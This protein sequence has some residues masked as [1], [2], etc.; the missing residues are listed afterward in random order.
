MNGSSAYSAQPGNITAVENQ[1][2]FQVRVIW[3]RS[4]W[5]LRQLLSGYPANAGTSRAQKWRIPTR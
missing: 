3:V 2:I 1:S 4:S 5:C